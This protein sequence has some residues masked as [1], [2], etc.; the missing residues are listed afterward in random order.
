MFVKL[1]RLFVCYEDVSTDGKWCYIVFW[2]VGKQRT[3]WSLLK[4][5]LM[6]ACPSCSSA[7]GISYYRTELQPPKPPDVF[8]LKFCCHDRKGLLHGN[9]VV[10]FLY[11]YL[12]CTCFLSCSCSLRFLVS[13]FLICWYQGFKFRLRLFRCDSCCCGKLEINAVAIGD[14]KNLDVAVKITVLDCFLKPLLILF[15]FIGFNFGVVSLH[16]CVCTCCSGNWLN[17]S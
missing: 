4:K 17:R 10:L 11:Y 8:L 5:R 3:G 7:S 16:P 2:V 1:I 12:S 9:Y 6:E 14:F 13:S 15:I